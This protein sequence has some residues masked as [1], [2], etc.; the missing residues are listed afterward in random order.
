MV[1]RKGAEVKTPKANPKPPKVTSKVAA[2]TP[3]AD[4]NSAK[5][6]AVVA[7]KADGKTPKPDAKPAKT[8]AKSSKKR[9]RSMISVGVEAQLPAQEGPSTA[10]RPAVET[11]EGR[12]STLQCLVKGAKCREQGKLFTSAYS[13]RY[14]Y[15][16]H[17]KTALI[18]RLKQNWPNF[19]NST[20]TCEQCQVIFQSRDILACH[21]GAKH[22]EVDAILARK[23]IPIP[24]EETAV[25]QPQVILNPSDPVSEPVV[26]T[27]TGE[28]HA[29]HVQDQIDQ[30]DLVDPQG[31][32]LGQNIDED[33]N[34]ICAGCGMHFEERFSL[35]VH[36]GEGHM[37]EEELAV[38]LLKAFPEGTS[39][40]ALC[41]MCGSV[42]QRKEH[43]MLEHPWTALE[44]LVAATVSRT[45][46][47]TETHENLLASKEGELFNKDL[48][49]YQLQCQVC[50]AVCPTLSQLQQHCTYHFACDIQTKFSNL[51]GESGKECLVCGF[52]AKSR[53]QVVTHLGCKHGKVNAILRERGFKSLPC[54]VAPNTQNGKEIQRKL[55][56]VKKERQQSVGYFGAEGAGIE[57]I[58]QPS[59]PAVCHSVKQC[60]MASSEAKEMD[61]FLCELCDE[62][63][64]RRDLKMHL[65]KE[66][67]ED[68]GAPSDLEVQIYFKP[69][70]AAVAAKI[71]A[72][73]VEEDVA[74]SV[75]KK[76]TPPVQLIAAERSVAETL[77]GATLEEAEAAMFWSCFGDAL[78]EEEAGDLDVFIVNYLLCELCD[79]KVEKRDLK[80]HLKKECW[81]I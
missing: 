9:A 5:A 35:K 13:L 6:E 42:Y 61:Y 66:H 45:V 52:T 14:H 37:E 36:I 77:E 39:T 38:Q 64:K 7:S 47:Q 8:E 24:Q 26:G 58:V 33:F 15:A 27:V 56:E 44:E 41:Q 34:F 1:K 31:S 75:S 18:N 79:E 73:S 25:V 43:V 20:N 48:V 78:V 69:S 53:S 16:K 72:K 17:A 74:Q 32:V 51:I 49:N 2:T 23:G 30:G 28:E 11:T 81:M 62:K 46:Q 19:T 59:H 21:I 54:P 29:V 67:R 55:V 65:N 50:E 63:V 3:K 68:I 57:N 71:A 60:A 40:C 12:T 76:A 4:A 80:A 70:P 22:G 10:N